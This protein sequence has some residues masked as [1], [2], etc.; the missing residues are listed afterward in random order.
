MTS[1]NTRALLLILEK[2]ENDTEVETKPPSVIIS[3]G[4]EGKSKMESIDS[5]ILKKSKQV[6]FS[7]K[8]CALCKKHGGLYKSHFTCD[9]CKFNPDGTPI[10]RNGG[11]GSA[12]RNRHADKNR[13]HQRDRK[14]TNFV[15][16][17]CKE[18]KKAFRKQSHKRKKCRANDSES[19][20][21]SD[22]SS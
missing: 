10:K 13:S 6:G 8:Q 20:S 12:R 1:V 21:N 11:T 4:T 3:K 7:D 2:I 16:I 17:I 15:Q 5:R 19:D 18:V 22:Y 9:C 14:G